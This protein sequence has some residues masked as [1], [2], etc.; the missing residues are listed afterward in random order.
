MDGAPA[1]ACFGDAEVKQHLVA[2]ASVGTPAG[3]SSKYDA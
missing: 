3:I 1:V 2:I